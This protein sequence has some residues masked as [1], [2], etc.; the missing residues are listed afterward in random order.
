MIDRLPAVLA[1]MMGECLMHREIAQ[2]RAS[3]TTLSK[4]DWGLTVR[5]L[6]V[7]RVSRIVPRAWQRLL[8]TAR[9]ITE[10]RIEIATW[11]NTHTTNLVDIST[12]FTRLTSLTLAWSGYGPR[13]TN[14]WKTFQRQLDLL[15]TT[16]F[17]S[18]QQIHVIDFPKSMHEHLLRWMTRMCTSHLVPH[19]VYVDWPQ[20][21]WPVDAYETF[22]SL[23]ALRCDTCDL[24]RRPPNLTLLWCNDVAHEP[25]TALLS[26]SQQ[27]SIQTVAFQKMNHK[28]WDHFS[29][30]QA[31]VMLH[32][33]S[34]LVSRTPTNHIT[35][36][37]LPAP[38]TLK[39]E[40]WLIYQASHGANDCYRPLLDTLLLQAANLAMD[41][42][43]TLDDKVCHLNAHT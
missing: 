23:L 35:C 42:P 10:M 17:E 7:G 27:R 11:R 21:V 37:N 20:V 22:T 30:I 32:G 6:D 41:A 3:C 8:R 26:S 13:N 33:A 40:E 14:Q 16:P 2:V 25:R 12:R 34:I 9:R 36:Y 18:L 29:L 1:L 19:L 24:N 39:D 15:I 4:L 5:R 38:I 31:H 43:W 28:Y